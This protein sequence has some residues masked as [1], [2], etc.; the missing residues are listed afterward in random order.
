MGFFFLM[1]WWHTNRILE[2]LLE[3]KRRQMLSPQE[4]AAEDK[5][6][7]EAEKAQ[8]RATIWTAVGGAVAVGGVVA[9]FYLSN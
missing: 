3:Q 6:R 4:R 1:Q 2:A 7:A 9:A 8:I 5:A